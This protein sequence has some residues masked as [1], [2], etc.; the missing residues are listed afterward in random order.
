MSQSNNMTDAELAARLAHE[1]GQILLN[2]RASGEFEGKALGAEGDAR[3]NAF[4]CEALRRLRPAMSDRGRQL[5][6]G[7]DYAS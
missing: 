1:A 6:N 4:L 7:A 2:V 3:A 5:R